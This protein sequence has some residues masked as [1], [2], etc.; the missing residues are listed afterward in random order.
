MLLG[1][2]RPVAPP[3]G[4]RPGDFDGHHA[5]SPAPPRLLETSDPRSAPG[6][7]RLAPS[8]SPPGPAELRLAPPGLRAPPRPAAPRRHRRL[9]LQRSRPA[10]S[11]AAGAHTRAA[12]TTG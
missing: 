12:R 5:I 7:T 2:R 8:A 6:A 10:R 1:S 9:A 11:D 3:A 4:L